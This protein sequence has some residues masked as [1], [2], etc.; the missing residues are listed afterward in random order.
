M[1]VASPEEMAAVFVQRFNDRDEL[2][3]WRFM[4]RMPCSHSARCCVRAWDG[5]DQGGAGRIPGFADEASAAS[6][7]A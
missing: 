5:R 2:G 4:R 1:G 6:M 3:C 7:R